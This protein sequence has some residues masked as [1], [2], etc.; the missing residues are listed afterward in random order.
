MEIGCIEIKIYYY[1]GKDKITRISQVASCSLGRNSCY[2]KGNKL[3]A[4]QPPYRNAN[5]PNI[6][7]IWNTAIILEKYITNFCKFENP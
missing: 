1:L 5:F 2:Y 6:C 7:C 4:V 3:Q